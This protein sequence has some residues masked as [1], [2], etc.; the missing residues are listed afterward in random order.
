MCPT[1]LNQYNHGVLCNPCNEGDS[2]EHNDNKS[3]GRAKPIP[4][5]L[6]TLPSLE[7]A[8]SLKG[9]SNDSY[10]RTSSPGKSMKLK[11]TGGK[12]RVPVLPCLR[13]EAGDYV[14]EKTSHYY[15]LLKRFENLERDRNRRRRA[16][17]KSVEPIFK[18]EQGN[19]IAKLETRMEFLWEVLKEARQEVILAEQLA[20]RVDEVIQDRVAINAPTG[21]R[22]EA[23]NVNG[24][25]IFKRKTPRTR[26]KVRPMKKKRNLESSTF[27]EFRGSRLVK[28]K[29]PTDRLPSRKKPPEKASPSYH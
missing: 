22:T 12:R 26:N 25:P 21:K 13:E 2:D 28:V 9:L 16:V 3:G 8:G 15:Q 27:V 24:D 5:T 20:N 6:N 19:I 11:E 29:D 23:I 4:P 18:V 17:E 1:K 14:E 7:G 10:I